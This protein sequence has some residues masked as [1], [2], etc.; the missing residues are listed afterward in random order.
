[1]MTLNRRELVLTAGGAATAMMTGCAGGQSAPTSPGILEDMAILR[2]ALAIHPGA[3]RYRTA[4]QIDADIDRLG[5]TLSATNDLDQRYL[6]FQRFLSRLKCGHT[7]ANFF[8]QSK[9]V[10]SDLFDRP[11]RLP[12]S[13][14]WL[15]DAMVVTAS[16]PG[17]DIAPGSIVTNI[18]GVKPGAMLEQLLAFT[19]ADGTALGKRKALLEVQGRSSIEY[20][21]V[22][23]GLVF[24]APDGG[25]HTLQL[26]TPQGQS[27]QMNVPAIGLDDRQALRAASGGAISRTDPLWQFEVRDDI[28][29]LTM[30]G[31][32]LFNTDWDW[33]TWLDARLDDASRLR[34]LIID[35]RDNEGGQI[36]VGGFL[37]SRLIRE[38]VALP[39]S[40]RLVRFR[41]F[42]EELRP[43]VSTWDPSFY[44]IGEN[45]KDVGDGFYEL[46]G[47]GG[48]P[49]ELPP[50]GQP[51]DVPVVLMT[52][53]TNSSAG[54]TFAQVG[55]QSGRMR[56]IGGETGGN[57]RG[58]N[59]DGFFFTTLP[60]LGIEF[61][62]PMVG[63]FPL[64]PQ[65]DSGIT[66]DVAITTTADDIAAGRDAPMDRALQ[67]IAA[68]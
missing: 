61:D 52:S 20:F 11:T 58:I 42:P 25:E 3:L 68:G 30:P 26:T 36:E 23:H 54:F 48:L 40:R 13:F 39:Q 66:P 45:A 67:D 17:D 5:Q 2:G 43:H 19:R 53:P 9:A 38:P 55:K 50:R 59:G 60:N 57:M 21:D 28:G 15:N 56:L 27:R 10:K 29:I 7:Y 31:W 32:A 34:G 63:R 12:F 47:S 1:M 18:N 37:L 8:N 44:S 62:L 22:F 24:G 41:T 16:A 6:A 14:R 65:P 33:A 46:R 49:P 4:Y 51:V 64:T 35:N